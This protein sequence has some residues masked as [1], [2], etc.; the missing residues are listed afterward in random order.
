MLV[1][2]SLV[3]GLVTA[4]GAGTA[5]GNPHDAALSA[6]EAGGILDNTP[7]D[8]GSNCS[9]QPIPRWVM[10]VWLIRALSNGGPV[11]EGTPRFSDVAGSWW[12]AHVERLAELGITRGCDDILFCPQSAVTRAQMATFL[13]RAF[14][15]DAGDPADFVDTVGNAHEKAI[16][17]LA[18]ARITAGCSSNPARYC[19][20]R[21]VTRGQ[22]ATFLAR[23]LDLVPL[24]KPIT[25]ESGEY[26]I[27]FDTVSGYR[28]TNTSGTDRRSLGASARNLS[29]SPDG[30][31]IVFDRYTST[32]RVSRLTVG[33]V[34]A[35]WSMDADGA[36]EVQ[37]T[38]YGRD[39]AWSP[40]GTKIAYALEHW[41]T[42]RGIW[43]MNADGSDQRLIQAGGRRPSWSPDGTR[44]AHYG[45]FLYDHTDE[46]IS[47][48]VHMMNSDGTDQ[49]QLT[50]RFKVRHGAVRV[51]STSF[52][53]VIPVPVVLEELHWSLDGTRIAYRRYNADNPPDR[54]W[55]L[56][57][58]EVDGKDDRRL[59]YGSDLSWSPDGTRIVYTDRYEL[60]IMNAD[61]TDQRRLAED[62]VDPAW[63]PDGTTIAY[64]VTNG[65]DNSYSNTDFELWLMDADGSNRRKLADGYDPVWLSA[66]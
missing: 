53:N 21:E 25:N 7:C 55:E 38:K 50:D 66:G 33:P 45:G 48:S 5:R 6:L 4:T 32:A 20:D 43:V 1:V 2:V 54:G 46:S 23:A 19:P 52:S 65:V 57:T 27:A 30:T 37:L 3:A 60:W 24:P 22:M 58:V 12:A 42:D 35:V 14:G 15:L 36:N 9:E 34:P 31:T 39:P 49:R 64:T 41:V 18:S 47:S 29:L 40:D 11:F 10:A 51:R 16:D 59:S 26:Y 63:S 17:A 44:I 28:V 8:D 61:G 13:T 62:G 56:W